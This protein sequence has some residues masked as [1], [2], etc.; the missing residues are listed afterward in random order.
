[1]GR[2]PC[3][4]DDGPGPASRAPGV[5][6]ADGRS[7]SEECAMARARLGSAEAPRHPGGCPASA[8][9]LRRLRDALEKLRA[10]DFSARLTWRAGVLGEV[11]DAFNAAAQA[12]ARFHGELGRVGR[13]VRRDGRLDERMELPEASGAF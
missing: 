1:Q 8:E 10:G 11:A 4:D 2:L 7:W 5:D 3:D 6:A 9:D 13:R 12:N